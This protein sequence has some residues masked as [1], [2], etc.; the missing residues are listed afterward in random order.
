M[1][2]MF[3]GSDAFNQPLNNWD[4]SNVRDMKK[5]FSG[6]VS[7]NQPL[8]N[9]DVSSVID[10]NAMFFYAP[11]FN[12]PLNS[13]NVSNVTNMQGMF[14]S[15]LG[16]N[17]LLGDWD[18]SN[19]TDMS[20]MLSAVGLS[21]ESYSQLLDGWSLRTLQ[22]SITFYIGAYYN[23][24]SAAAHQYIMD[25]YNWYILDN[26]ELP[27]TA[28]S[29]GPSITMWDEGITTVSQ[30]SDLKL[31]AYAVDD[32]DGAVAV[33]TSGSVNT[34]VLGVYTLTYTASD[35]AGNTS[36]ATREITVE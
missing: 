2:S 17:Q 27:E 20:N 33:T 31:Y 4:V 26:G 35:S 24:E 28:D 5:M 10:M 9:W 25:N 6:A 21:T 22:P 12:Q 34:S 19:V 18:I 36:T 32:R 14:S 8:N 7:F 1:S 3:S 16:F 13:W 23:S 15:A 29:T 11:V 30:Y